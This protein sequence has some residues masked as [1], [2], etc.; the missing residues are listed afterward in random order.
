MILTILMIETPRS[1]DASRRC[2]NTTFR[3]LIFVKVCLG[4]PYRHLLFVL[5]LRIRILKSKLCGFVR[6]K[7]EEQAGVEVGVKSQCKEISR[8]H[9]IN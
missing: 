9:I 2:N 6:D 8:D 5:E 4:S 3:H 1:C 7:R